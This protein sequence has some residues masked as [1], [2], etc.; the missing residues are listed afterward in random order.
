MDETR[1]AKA[2]FKTRVEVH[3]RT[4]Y[5][6]APGCKLLGITDA[7]PMPMKDAKSRELMVIGKDADGN[8]IC[9]SRE[10]A[11]LQ[12]WIPTLEQ[13]EERKEE[14]GF[15]FPQSLRLRKEARE[16]ALSIRVISDP[17]KDYR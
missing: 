10:E 4:N 9:L 17:R 8:P 11:L 2:Y 15:L 6:N 3:L 5:K 1:Q 7:K 16:E 13:I 14:L 12:F